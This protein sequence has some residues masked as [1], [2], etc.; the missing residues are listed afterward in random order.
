LINS[1]GEAVSSGIYFYVLESGVDKKSG[2][3]GVI[4]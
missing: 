4:R 1:A 3:L 2:K